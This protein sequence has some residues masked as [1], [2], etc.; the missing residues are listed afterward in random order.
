MKREFSAGGIVLRLV[1]RLRSGLAQDK[2]LKN[3]VEVLLTKHSQNK[4][5]SFPKGWIEEGQTAEQAAVREVKEE[6]GVEAE[7][8]DKVGYSKYVYTLNNE[9]IFK[10]VTYFLMK[11]VSGDPKDHDW[12]VEEA[13]WFEVADALKTLSFSHD[14]E[15]LKEAVKLWQK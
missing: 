7:I 11:Y 1:P 10:V 9:K 3:K 8:L 13:G 15:L 12:E 14:K 5:W 4:N 6:G 2:F